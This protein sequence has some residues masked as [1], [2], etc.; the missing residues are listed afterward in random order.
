MP[1]PLG[2]TKSTDLVLTG[3][4]VGISPTYRHKSRLGE[5]PQ[6]A[7]A[8]ERTAGFKGLGQHF[9]GQG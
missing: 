2:D 9:S 5:R 6:N 1:G 4:E 3:L 7:R 8:N